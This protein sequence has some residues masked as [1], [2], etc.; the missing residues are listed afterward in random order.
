MM[1]VAGVIEKYLCH[2]FVL[3]YVPDF[4]ICTIVSVVYEFHNVVEEFH[5][6]PM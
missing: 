1:M 3:Y 5:L 2:Y 4:R 6:S